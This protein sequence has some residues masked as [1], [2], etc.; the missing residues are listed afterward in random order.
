MEGDREVRAFLS[1]G[2]IPQISNT[3]QRREKNFFYSGGAGVG[4]ARNLR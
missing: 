1:V 4:L 3:A 2:S